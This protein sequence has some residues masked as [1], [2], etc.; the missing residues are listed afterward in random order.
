MRAPPPITVA[1]AAGPHWRMFQALTCGLTALV[2]A[3][4]A[5]E[6]LFPGLVAWV[7][8][9][10]AGVLALAW[11]WRVSVSRPGRLRWDGEVWTLWLVADAQGGQDH[12]SDA[13]EAAAVRPEVM[14]DLGPWMLLKLSPAAPSGRRAIGWWAISQ[15]LAGASWH[16][17]RA[18]L[19]SAA[20]GLSPRSDL[21][22]PP[23]G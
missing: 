15:G 6:H 5:G 12:T 22:H 1:L 18:A 14:L 7:A 2:L 13:A 19:Y 10:A 11:G 4:W 17:F 16:P 21:E 20:S 23:A 3:G 9:G 8:A